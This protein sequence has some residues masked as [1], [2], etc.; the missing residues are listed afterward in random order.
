MHRGEFTIISTIIND[1]RLLNISPINF[2]E[3]QTLELL[4]RFKAKL[5]NAKKVGSNETTKST[6]NKRKEQNDGDEDEGLNDDTWL[7]HTLQFEVQGEILAKDASTKKD[8]WYDV[9][10]PRNPINKRKRG[11]EDRHSKR[12]ERR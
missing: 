3:Q 1:F 10:D 7:S 6:D 12:K 5:E 4:N 9:Y 11:E 2:R 8:D